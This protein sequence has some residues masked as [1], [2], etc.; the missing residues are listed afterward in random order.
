MDVIQLLLMIILII[1]GLFL[2]YQVVLKILGGSWQTEDIIVS[3]LILSISFTFAIALNQIRYSVD[4]NYFKRN[5]HSLAKD[6]KEHVSLNN[7]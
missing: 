7:E 4:Y 3:L 5:I 1:F 6:F 2:L